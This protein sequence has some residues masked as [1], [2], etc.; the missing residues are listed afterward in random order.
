MIITFA[1]PTTTTTGTRRLLMMQSPIPVLRAMFFLWFTVSVTPARVTATTIASERVKLLT[2][3]SYSNITKQVSLVLDVPAGRGAQETT[4]PLSLTFPSVLGLLADLGITSDGLWSVWTIFTNV[5]RQIL[6]TIT[7]GCASWMLLVICSWVR[8]ILRLRQARREVIR[9]LLRAHERRCCRSACRIQACWKAWVTAKRRAEA[10]YAVMWA[11]EEELRLV[12]FRERRFPCPWR[13][14]PG[15]KPLVG[16]PCPRRKRSSHEQR[17]AARVIKPRKH[18]AVLCIQSRWRSYQGRKRLRHERRLAA[19][20]LQQRNSVLCIQAGW[21]AFQGRKDL[22]L[23]QIGNHGVDD[24][25]NS[26]WANDVYPPGRDELPDLGLDNTLGA[27]DNGTNEFTPVPALRRSRRI[28]EINQGQ[29]NQQQSSLILG[30]RTD[31]RSGLVH[32]GPELRRSKR[33]AAKA[34]VNYKGM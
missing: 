8:Q 14:D 25:C 2:G 19:R 18:Y 11:R 17:S 32:V 10:E 5:T 23:V 12:R 21:R 33:L 24:D 28:A 30:A 1:T 9:R 16:R 31:P 3:A 20:V 4:L 27:D 22:C 7:A 13:Q 15:W 29:G 34:R 26:I 6:T